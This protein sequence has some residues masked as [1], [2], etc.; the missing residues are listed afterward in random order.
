MGSGEVAKIRAAIAARVPELIETMME[1]ALGGDVAAARLLLE[2]AVA[3][4]KAME[5]T[6]AISLPTGTLSDQA[7]AVL[8]SVASGEL[9]TGQGAQLLA[10]IGALGRVVEVDELA[11]RIEALEAKSKQ[12]PTQQR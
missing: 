3:P 5:P 12:Q 10:A 9:G 2:R 11:A 4:L 8:A 6:Q 1:R 7:R